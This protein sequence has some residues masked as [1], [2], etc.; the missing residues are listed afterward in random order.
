MTYHSCL[1]AFEDGVHSRLNYPLHTGLYKLSESY[2]RIQHSR[3]EVVRVAEVVNGKRNPFSLRSCTNEDKA[4]W[5]RDVPTNVA[6]RVGYEIIPGLR[7]LEFDGVPNT[8]SENA[9]RLIES[10][11]PLR[12]M[13]WNQ[14]R[15]TYKNRIASEYARLRNGQSN[16]LLV[17]DDAL[18]MIDSALKTLPLNIQNEV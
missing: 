10:A 17:V 11:I 16:A 8:Q 2:K 1:E 9:A 18:S 15:N 13:Q 12:L 5:L 14:L 6:F 4:Y 7:A 3:D